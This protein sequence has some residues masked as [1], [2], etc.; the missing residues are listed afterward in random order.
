MKGRKRFYAS[1]TNSKS[2]PIE[3]VNRLPGFGESV[4]DR[5]ERSAG[6][7]SRQV[8]AICGVQ[9]SKRQIAPYEAF[10]IG[11]QSCGPQM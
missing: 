10:C 9:K 8:R 5:D 4:Y 6:F 3:E 1:S 2:I 7:I 11:K